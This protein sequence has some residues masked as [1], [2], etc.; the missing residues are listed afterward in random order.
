MKI[1]YVE[2]N[3]ANV[4]LVR[5]VARQHELVNYIDG[6]E[7]LRD[8]DKIDPDLVLMDIQLAGRLTGLD[9]V[10]ALRKAGHRVPIIAVTA[11]AMVG[12]REK[13]LAAGCDDYIPKPLPVARL[14]MLFQEYAERASQQVEAPP[15]LPVGNAAQTAATAIDDTPTVPVSATTTGD[16]QNVESSSSAPANDASKETSS[17]VKQTPEAAARAGGADPAAA[18]S[19]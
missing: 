3:L 5:R 1:L 12:D 14:V 4:S 7:A 18:G 15:P 16:A 8:F 19:S 13:C 6:E 9:V 10:R 11:Y 2:D 17:E